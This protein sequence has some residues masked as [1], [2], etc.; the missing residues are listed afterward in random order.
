MVAYVAEGVK[1]LQGLVCQSELSGPGESMGGALSFGLRRLDQRPFLQDPHLKRVLLGRGGGGILFQLRHHERVDVA[2][3][4]VQSWAVSLGAAPGAAAG[5]T[6]GI[7]PALQ[8]IQSKLLDEGQ[9]L[10][11]LSAWLRATAWSSWKNV[12]VSS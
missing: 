11:L 5:A 10:P 1:I 6:V 4:G 8:A 9:S 12:F 2:F 3:L 7:V